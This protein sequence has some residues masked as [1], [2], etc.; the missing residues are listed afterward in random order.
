MAPTVAAAHAPTRAAA[1]H[2]PNDALQRDAGGLAHAIARVLPRPHG[3]YF[4]ADPGKRRLIAYLCASNRVGADDADALAA[5]SMRRLISAFAPDAPDGFI[6][7]LKR[8][9]G[10]WG[11]GQYQ[12]LTSVLSAGDDGA[13]ALR[14]IAAIDPET[15]A[16]LETLPSALRRL[17]IVRLL[18]IPY[19]ADLLTRTVKQA[20]GKSPEPAR[21]RTLVQRLERASSVQAAFAWLVEEVG[22]AR[23][24]PPP[25]PGTDWLRPI[26]DVRDIERTALKFQN[27]LRTRVPMMLRGQAAYFEVLGEEPAVVEVLV[28]RAQTWVVGEIRG[29]AND[30]VSEALMRTITEYLR[31]HCVSFNG[32]PSRLALELAEAAGW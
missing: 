20:W 4:D 1:N 31:A 6:E 13:K 27:C 5:W 17:K 22:V 21:L 9:K 30:A 8:A 11:L 12:A 7:A 16:M 24:T 28:G 14:H 32:R 10:V 26:L 19:Y 2:T 15:L 23:I 25:I 3:A 29:H 18:Q